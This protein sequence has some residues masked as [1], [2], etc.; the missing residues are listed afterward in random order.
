MIIVAYNPSRSAYSLRNRLFGFLFQA[1]TEKGLFHK[2]VSSK[3]IETSI[4]AVQDHFQAFATIP[5][6][7]RSRYK[8]R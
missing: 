4:M 5:T 2:M 6:L 3:E 8:L 7:L 1:E